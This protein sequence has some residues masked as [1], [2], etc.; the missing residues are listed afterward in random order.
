ML[1]AEQHTQKNTL[2]QVLG[3]VVV[4]PLL[5]SFVRLPFPLGLLLALGA[6]AA[7]AYGV[8][9][10]WRHTSRRVTVFAL[11]VTLLNIISLMAIGEVSLLMGLYRVVWFYGYP[12]YADWVYWNH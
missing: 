11:V 7:S 1:E 6:I 8:T 9:F 12:Y 10:A 5:I 2:R 3:W 4:L